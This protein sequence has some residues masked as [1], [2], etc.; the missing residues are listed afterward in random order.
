VVAHL[1]GVHEQH[2]PLTRRERA[3]DLVAEVNVPGGVDQ[4]QQVVNALVAIDERHRLGLVG[5]VRSSH[6][7]NAT[8]TTRTP[9]SV[10]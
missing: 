5:A 4:V 2:S 7:V 9:G 1:G 3:A 8:T 6:V 10:P